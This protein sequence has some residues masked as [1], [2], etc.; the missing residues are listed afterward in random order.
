MKML[1]SRGAKALLEKVKLKPGNRVGLILPNL[2]EYPVVVYAAMKAG[3]V[4]TFANPLSTTEEIT[5]QFRNAEVQCIMTIPMLLEA[6]L[7]VARALPN[8]AATINIGGETDLEKN[9]LGMQTIFTEEFQVELPEVK[10]TD[11]AILPYSSGTTGLPK[12]V[13]LSHRNLVA[14]LIQCSYSALT[15]VKHPTPCSQETV[16]SVLPFFHIYGFNGILNFLMCHGVHIVTLPRFTPEDYLRCLAEYKP[17]TI[18]VVPS[19]LLFLATHAEVTAKDLSSIRRVICGAAPATKNLIDKFKQ[20][21]NHAD[22]TVEQGYGM[23]ET[24]PVVLYTPQETPVS[25]MG[26]CGRL[27]P[28]TEARLISLIDGSDITLPHNP[29]ELLIRGPQLMQGYLNDRSSTEN[30]I[31]VHGWLHTGDVTYY[32]EDGYF[33][34]VDRTKELIKV[35]GNQV[36]PTELEG[37]ILEVTGVADVAVIGVPDTMAGELPK[38]FI[39]KHPG[40]IVTPEIINDYI[41]PKVAPY[42]KLAG[43]ITFIEA[44]PR[45]PSGKVLRNQLKVFGK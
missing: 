11:I 31:D 20:K 7:T 19:L 4:V 44:I 29:G 12:G 27:L 21:L 18:F 6:A 33:F 36:S 22:C 10:S 42:K 37:I 17:T 15:N 41:T 5:R 28:S 26:T 38:A 43:G 45:N 16:L 32:D 25:K 23:T 2:P 24:S 9:V 30:S 40:A 39:V 35:K 13:M 34:I 1:S 3:L 8:Y 14:N